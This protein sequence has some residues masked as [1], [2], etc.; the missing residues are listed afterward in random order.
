MIRS[1]NESQL[2]D[3]G[4]EWIKVVQDC[5]DLKIL[6]SVL[7][8]ILLSDD[9]LKVLNQSFSGAEDLGGQTS[10]RLIRALLKVLNIKTIHAKVISESLNGILRVSLD[11]LQV[12]SLMFIMELLDRFLELDLSGPHRMDLV[13]LLKVEEGLR[14]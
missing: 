6:E 5:V 10:L 3:A 14:D 7:C 1:L 4:V 12:L 11:S 8:F 13:E 9:I 2:D